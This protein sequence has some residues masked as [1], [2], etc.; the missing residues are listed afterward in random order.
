MLR[1]RSLRLGF[2]RSILALGAGMLPVLFAQSALG[3]A[4]VLVD[5]SAD[6]HTISP[7]IFGLNFPSNAQLDQ[8]KITVGRW[9]GNSVTRYN[10]ENDNVNTAADY[11]FENIP[12]CWG[13]DQNYCQNPPND[14]KEQSSA[15]AFLKQMSD[16]GAVAL[17]TIPTIGWVAKMESPAKYNHP[18][19]CGCPK[20]AHPN[21]SSFDPYDD[22]CGDGLAPGGGYIDC[23]PQTTSSV[24]TTPEWAKTWVTYLVQKFG[25]SNG[26]RIYALDNEPA[27][28]S[29]THHDIRKEKLGYD[30]LWQRMRD[31]AVAILEADPTAEIAGPAEWGWPNYLCSD[32]DDISQGCGPNNPDRAAHGGEELVAWLLDQAKAYEQQNGKR[33]LHY[34]DL[35]YYPQGGN[36]PENTR[37]LWDPNY[38]DPSWI[39][40]NIR[41]L[42]RMRDWVDQHYPGTKLAISEYDFYSHD[43][44]VGGV[45]YAE[46]LGLFAR[47]GAHVATAWGPPD[48]SE[49]AFAAYRLYRNYDGQGAGFEKVSVKATSDTSGVEAYAAAGETRL[50]VALVNEGFGNASIEVNVG[51]FEPDPKATLYSNNGGATIANAGQ[52]DV[53][54]G[55]VT[56]QLPAESIGMLVVTGKNPNQLPTGGT[57]GTGGSGGSSTGGGATGGNGSGG[58][59]TGGSG[60][61]NNGGGGGSGSGGGGGCGCRTAGESDNDAAWLVA[62]ALGMILVKRRRDRR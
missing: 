44:A 6:Q 58:N 47:E 18:F 19:T 50:T 34:L 9:G 21:Q 5:P 2:T 38:T 48:P 52:F 14:P 39:N 49:P 41:L 28:W 51:N 62:A 7:L 24:A 55:A 33:I 10:Y 13:G 29:S 53:T 61:G 54:N 8:G 4:K 3:Q 57:G 32:K 37:S 56:V 36:A 43:Q 40:D 26:K 60:A 31:Y 22:N 20:S 46:V 35:H 1:T 25:P 27:L 15:N 16:K 23:G 42:P 59:G 45:T 11:Y 30:E 17:F 12:G